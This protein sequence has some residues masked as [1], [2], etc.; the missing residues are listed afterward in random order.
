MGPQHCNQTGDPKGAC[1]RPG[2]KMSNHV[3]AALFVYTDDSIDHVGL[4]QDNPLGVRVTCVAFETLMQKPKRI[5]FFS[6]AS[7][8]RFR[9]LLA[10]LR[11]DASIRAL[12]PR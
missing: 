4:L 6:Y 7:S 8:E 9:D 10:A 5:P 12:E 1:R 2:K 3:S 11:E